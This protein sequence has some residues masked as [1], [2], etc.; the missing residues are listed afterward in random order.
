MKTSR[1]GSAWISN[2]TAP[3]RTDLPERLKRLPEL[4]TDLWWTWNPRARE[5]FRKLD[6]PLWRQTAHNPVLMLQ[7]VSPEM[8][9]LAAADERFLRRLRRGDRRARRARG[10]ARDTWW[11]ERFPD[12]QRVRSP[13]SRRSSRCTSR[14]RST[15]AVSA[16]WPAITA[17]KPATSG[18]RSS[19]SA[20][21]IRRATSTRPS[22]PK[23]GSRKSTNS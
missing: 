3:L 22:R 14:C 16:C 15:P 1:E 19:A 23:A 8:L 5:V 2:V 20:S 17:R 6:Y 4:A 18:F 7:L 10:S 13:I 9:A 11:H 21:C 12:G